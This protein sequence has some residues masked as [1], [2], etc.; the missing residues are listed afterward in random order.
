MT[1]AAI[2]LTTIS[3]ISFAAI[4]VTAPSM[5][6]AQTIKRPP[7]L[8]IPDS[9]GRNVTYVCDNAGSWK[10]DEF[11]HLAAP[12][13][14][15]APS[16]A[17][18]SENTEINA[19]VRQGVANFTGMGARRDKSGG[20]RLIVEAA[21]SGN[22][23]AQ[24]NLAVLNERGDL[25]QVDLPS[26]IANY[27]AAASQGLDAAQNA[28]GVHYLD[29]VG[30]GRD[31]AQAERWFK[32]AAVQGYTKAYLNMAVIYND[33]NQPATYNPDLA[34]TWL[35]KA[36]PSSPGMIEYKI[37]ATQ[38]LAAKYRPPA[39][40]DRITKIYVWCSLAYHHLSPPPSEEYVP[41]VVSGPPEAETA[42]DLSDA[43]EKQL[44]GM[45]LTTPG[46]IAAFL[47]ADNLLRRCLTDGV[48]S[49]GI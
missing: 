45:A 47:R 16:P 2:N 5:A 29:G 26:A 38:A 49:C 18:S 17:P 11:A 24:F 1:R 42:G 39:S 43:A 35:R 33:P 31:R 20:I 8:A 6:Q 22:R 7:C 13:V 28:L 19:K 14:G 46:G 36:L 44:K 34:T 32:A 37:C 27:Q 25:G 15:K 48:D 12:Q 21:A 9:A 41:G 40:V 23:Y 3:A 10:I 30:V 4:A